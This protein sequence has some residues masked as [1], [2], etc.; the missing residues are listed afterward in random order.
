MR[1]YGIATAGDWLICD[2]FVFNVRELMSS[3][4]SD[5]SPK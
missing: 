5:Q 4:S 3:K 1:E 2:V